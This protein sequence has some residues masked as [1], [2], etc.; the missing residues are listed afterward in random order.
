MGT[1]EVD[2]RNHGPLWAVARPVTD[3]DA[4]AAALLERITALEQALLDAQRALEHAQLESH[5][6]AA[7]NTTQSAR[8]ELQQA[9]SP[10]PTG[11]APTRRRWWLARLHPSPAYERLG[12]R[13]EHLLRLTEAASSVRVSPLAAASRSTWT[14]TRCASSG[15]I[16]PR[17]RVRCAGPGLGAPHR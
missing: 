5:R 15:G 13:V 1:A 16:R 4:G 8:A 9:L 11:P 10:A 7:Y 6:A 14:S 12:H 17:R 2:A 3:G